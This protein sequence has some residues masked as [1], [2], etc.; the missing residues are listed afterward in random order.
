LAL[1]VLAGVER[2]GCSD[3]G[4]RKRYGEGLHGGW[5][6]SSSR[7]CGGLACKAD[8]LIEVAW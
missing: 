3:G 8:N 1:A 2:V 6:V 5:V 4:E 7:R